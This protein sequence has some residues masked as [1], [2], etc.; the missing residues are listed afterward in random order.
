MKKVLLFLL[1]VTITFSVY[2]QDSSTVKSFKYPDYLCA[3]P[4]TGEPICG[5]NVIEISYSSK[6]DN[7]GIDFKYGYI[8]YMLSLSYKGM[9]NG[10][11]VYSG[12][13]IESM[14]EV[15]VKTSVKLSRFL[16][17]YG[18]TQEER[19]E[20][21]KL[22]EVHISGMGSLSIYPIKDTPERRKKI[23]ETRK[24]EE[25]ARRQKEEKERREREE[26]LK[27]E[28]EMGKLLSS[29]N[30]SVLR[31]KV[32]SI[33][34][35]KAC[36]KVRSLDLIE[37]VTPLKEELPTKVKVLMHVD[38][39]GM[40][41]VKIDDDIVDH[42]LNVLFSSASNYCVVNGNVCYKHGS[43]IFFLMEMEVPV[44][45][46]E[47]WVC[48]LKN[49]NGNFVYYREAPDKV[50]EWCR[51]NIL[52]NG[53][54]A[55]EY[56]ICGDKCIINKIVVDKKSEQFIKGKDPHKAKKVWKSIGG[57]ILLGGLVGVSAF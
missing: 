31:Y 13:E 16:N 28:K 17:N 2:A 47:M 49:R 8:R 25:E 35:A 18:Q 46:L 41:I 10:G 15:V 19:F 12:F 20:K 3:N 21:D 38:S 48:G 57:A 1:S 40:T 36:K 30:E 22:I 50:Q 34:C 42:N 9:S 52:T 14:A 37:S 51:E 7:Y 6:R 43:N 11:Y 24:Q 29:I 39:L 53:F 5:G 54:H 45:Y 44:R 4:F 33:S 26:L 55:I 23:E 56:V 27:R 32:D